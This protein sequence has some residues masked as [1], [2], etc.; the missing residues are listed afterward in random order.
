M[1]YIK[2]KSIKWAENVAHM[3][4]MQY[5]VHSTAV[6]KNLS[7][8]LLLEGGGKEKRDRHTILIFILI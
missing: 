1:F 2:L 6:S 8:A 5:F 3:E 7:V 4:G